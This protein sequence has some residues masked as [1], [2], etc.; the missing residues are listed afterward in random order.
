[1]DGRSRRP[2]RDRVNALLSYGYSSL[3]RETLAAVIA[4]GLH[5]GVG[6]YHQPRS[7]SHTLALDVMELFRVAIV[8]MAIVAAINR[9][10]FDETSDFRSA[11]GQVLLTESGRD[12]L[13]SVLE[14]RK[15]DEWRHPVVGYSLS[16]ARMIEL[17]VRLLEKEWMGEG[18]LFA[19]MRLR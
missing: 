19:R 6:F 2:P 7:A 1:M 13:L 15:T 9:R 5:P 11:P 10:S 4:V 14:R 8:D 18:G 12:K 3:Y 17:E 16:Y